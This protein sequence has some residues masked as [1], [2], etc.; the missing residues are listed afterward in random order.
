MNETIEM[1]IIP[2]KEFFYSEDSSF[3]IYACVPEKPEL[4]MVNRKFNTIS[5]KGKTVRLTL[6]KE[7]N[8]KLTEKEDKKYGTYYE[9][10]S[11]YE[12]IP[13]DISKQRVYLQTLLTDKQVEAIYEVYPNEDI[14]ELIKD[15]QFDYGKVKGV[16][17]KTYLNIKDKLIENLE[18]KE[19]Y[20]FFEK[21]GLTNEFIVKL[22]K[23][24]KS[25]KLLIE[26]V[27]INPYSII[28]IR[29]I[30]FKKADK[31]A[32]SLGYDP[33]GKFRLLSAIEFS[34][35]EESNKGHTYVTTDKL[36]QL[37]Q[38]LTSVDTNL[39][40]EYIYD[41]ENI[42]VIGD[43][44]TL[45]N[46]Y[47]AEKYIAERVNEILSDGN[48]LNFNVEEFIEEQEKK[49]GF[50]LTDQQK[51][52]FYNI[53]QY[54]FNVL[55]G[56]AGCGKSQML[57]LLI[58][59]LENLHM[60]YR[61]LSPTGKAAKVVS[62]YTKRNAETIH[63]AIG[64]GMK[65]EDEERKNIHEQFVIVDEVSMV[66]VRLCE[67][68][69]KKCKHHNVR[70]LFI[71]DP[72]QIPAVSAG[73]VLHDLIESKETPLTKLD[74]VFRQ[75]EGGMLD[76]ITKIRLNQK[77]L[78]ND[79]WGIM[80]FGDNC[81][82]ACVPQ[83]K[84][85]GGYQYY[86]NQMLQEYSSDEITVATPT[87]KSNLGTI[88]INKHIQTIVNDKSDDKKEKEYGYDKVIFREGDLL[89]NTVN[90][91][92]ILDINE[93]EVDIVNGDIG[94]VIKIDE[95]EK[96]IIVDFEFAIIPFPFSKLN[97]LL[98]C[99]GLTVHKLQGSANS[100]VIVI[101]D[102][103]HKFQ[104]NNNL[105]YTACTRPTD[106]LIIISQAETINF[107]MRKK[108]NLQRNTFLQEFLV[109]EVN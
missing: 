97:Q 40:N 64:L 85:E 46:N 102:K 106:K 59:L 28:E 87:K 104:L 45:K 92:R 84:V 19:A 103:A 47:E 41:T 67:K 91:Y 94:K 79:D 95:M 63:R 50:E 17:K 37:V 60:S 77:F 8:A 89:I 5:V 35:E 66:D 86:F 21:F 13:T 11:I 90:S 42:L 100:T 29:G 56:F 99:W 82:I 2:D 39:I 68:L 44:V 88:N 32:M 38:E 26:K 70:V 80:N 12:E 93:Q 1:K 74:I 16:G 22:V 51:Q 7:Y 15:D 83:D 57:T 48:E 61:L 53:K 23:H 73:N 9:I 101:A 34:V 25:A 6:D 78:R 30:G 18:F 4:V 107:A 109:E 108:A 33:E 54:N 62:K 72:A 98:H 65:K 24:F 10:V 43:R 36:V 105:L 31:I 96:E 81:T 20:D 76:I 52:F 14:I 71:G 3:G 55:T 69:L 75:K 27:K 49:Q 58:D